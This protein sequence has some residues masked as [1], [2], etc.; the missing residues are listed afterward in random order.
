MLNSG[1]WC[2][3][4]NEMTEITQQWLLIDY[5]WLHIFLVVKKCSVESCSDFVDI[6]LTSICPTNT[7]HKHHTHMLPT[8]HKL[9]LALLTASVHWSF[10]TAFYISHMTCCRRRFWHA[11]LRL[12]SATRRHH[13]PQRAVLSQICCYCFGEH[14]VVQPNL[15]YADQLATSNCMRLRRENWLMMK[16]WVNTGT[17]GMNATISST[18]RH[19]CRLTGQT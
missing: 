4:C 6:K 5:N 1:L 19:N 10:S 13:P 14:K 12:R 15:S 3:K 2:Q 9:L 18:W 16:V 11:T 7:S 8:H 17:Q